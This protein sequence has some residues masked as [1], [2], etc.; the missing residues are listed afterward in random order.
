MPVWV[1]LRRARTDSLGLNDKCGMEKLLTEAVS[2]YLYSIHGD[3]APLQQQ[4]SPPYLC[5]WWLTCIGFVS[6]YFPGARRANNL[7]FDVFY[8]CLSGLRRADAVLSAMSG[9]GCSCI[10][11]FTVRYNGGKSSSV[12][13]SPANREPLIGEALAHHVL[14]VVIEGR[15]C[16][17]YDSTVLAGCKPRH[18]WHAIYL[19]PICIVSPGYILTNSPTRFG[20]IYRVL[21]RYGRNVFE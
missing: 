16:L 12:L 20:D 11:H 1:T 13:V 2:R 14:D 21:R 5:P 17:W 3:L 6:Y 19:V 15:T 9:G 7:P 4:R 10:H 8:Y 18:V